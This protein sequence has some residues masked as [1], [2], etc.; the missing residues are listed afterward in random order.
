MDADLHLDEMVRVEGEM[1]ANVERYEVEEEISVKIFRPLKDILVNVEDDG[2]ATC[3]S[4]G[5][6]VLMVEDVSGEDVATKDDERCMQMT[7]Y[8]WKKIWKR[9]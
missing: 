4:E 9:S 8:K 1:I 7:W 6:E 2:V 5:I 3:L